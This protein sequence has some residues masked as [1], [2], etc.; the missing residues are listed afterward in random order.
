MEKEFG[1]FCA[2]TLNQ[3]L[4]YNKYKSNNKEQYSNKEISLMMIY[5]VR[6]VCRKRND[7]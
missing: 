6:Y 2:R 3:E 5:F 4:N 1:Q 7:D